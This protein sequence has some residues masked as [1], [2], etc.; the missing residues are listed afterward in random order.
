MKD[1][2]HLRAGLNIYKGALTYKA[3]AEA[4]K[5]PFTDP[6]TVLGL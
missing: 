6:A 4:Q 3:V 5:R 2:P 1:D